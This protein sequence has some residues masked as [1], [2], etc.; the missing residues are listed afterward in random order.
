MLE[1]YKRRVQSKGAYIGDMVKNQSD[2]IMDATFLRDVAT[3]RCYI[4]NELVYAKFQKYTTY[5][6]NKD[7]IDYHL[8]FMTGVHYP[9]GTYVY[10]PDDTGEYNPWLIVGRDDDSQFVKYSV[11]KCN[12]TLWWIYNGKI[13]SC[14]GVIK[15]NGTSIAVNSDQFTTTV[16]GN[17]TV[18]LP[19][20]SEVQTIGYNARFL[21]TKNK[22]N[23]SSFKVTKILD[24]LPVGITKLGMMQD[25][26]DPKADKLDLIINGV[27]VMIADY[28]KSAIEPELPEE[29]PKDN[30]YSKIT[31]SNAT[32]T[33]KIGGNTQTLIATF[34]TEDGTELTNIV[35][36]WSYELPIGKEDQFI[37]E[38]TEVPNKVKIRA[39]KNYSILE[40]VITIKVE[41]EDGLYK[42]DLRLEVTA[43]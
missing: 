5:S 7:V 14:L 6:I 23:P 8:Q 20:T 19:T 37:I 1:L 4:D 25:R 17:C 3:K 43:I 21:I 36:V 32:P 35:P 41:S 11:L 15:S 40:L 29:P 2:K 24:T 38:T 34:Y 12:W 22:V 33:L 26:Y 39:L 18:W 9:E 10:I 28:Y 16:D 31:Y 13:Y 27:E 30:G 42:S